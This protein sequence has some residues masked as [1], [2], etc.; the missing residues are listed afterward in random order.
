[1]TMHCDLRPRS[2][3]AAQKLGHV[4]LALMRE[5]GTLQDRFDRVVASGDLVAVFTEDFPPELRGDWHR[6]IG[7]L[8]P[9]DRKLRAIRTEVF[10]GE[11]I[12]KRKPAEKMDPRRL[13]EWV[14]AL[15]VLNQE[16]QAYDPE[17]SRAVREIKGLLV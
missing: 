16:F 12:S 11:Y 10:S 1:M 2:R 9:T 3:Y 13:E 17:G 8:Y 5:P 7:A 14:H 15:L 4:I 6:L